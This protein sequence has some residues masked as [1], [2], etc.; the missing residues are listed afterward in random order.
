[1]LTL[2]PELKLSRNVSGVFAALEHGDHH[3]LDSNRPSGRRGMREEGAQTEPAQGDRQSRALSETGHKVSRARRLTKRFQG[4]ARESSTRG[5][6]FANPGVTGFD[7]GVDESNTLVVRQEC[8]LHGIDRDLLEIVDGEAK[9]FRCGCEFLAQGGLAHQAIVR[10]QR[11]PEFLLIKNSEGMLRQAGRSPGVNVAQQADL[12]RDT[13][14]ENVLRQVAQLHRLA[15][16]HGNIVNQPRSVADAVR[17]A[18]LNRL[19]DRFF[20]VSCAGVNRDVEVLA[21]Y[22]MKSVD[23]LLRRIAAL[24]ARQIEANHSTRAKIYRQFRHFKRGV[25]VAHRANDE[26]GGDSKIFSPALHAFQNRRNNLLVG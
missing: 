16:H 21:L 9:G 8:A 11:D 14:V 22:V 1:M 26:S 17:S 10:V 6:R 5:Q 15:V 24:L 13:F 19:P 4:N 7:G 12:E 2:H 3:Y 20:S 23:M 18:I 25:H